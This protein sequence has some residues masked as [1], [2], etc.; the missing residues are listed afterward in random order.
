M[1]LEPHRLLREHAGEVALQ[2][3]V[4]SLP[5]AELGA[6]LRGRRSVRQ[7]GREP[8]T[9]AQLGTLLGLAAGATDDP[10]LPVAGFGPPGRRTY[11]S[12]GALYP[13]EILVHELAGPECHLYQVFTHRLVRFAAL[14]DSS[15][16]DAMVQENRIEGTGIGFFLF[17]DFARPSLR[18]Y[19]QLAER[20]ALLEAG[21][22][23]QN[24]L[25]VGTALGL[26][27]V[28]LCGFDVQGL[29]RSL[30]LSYPEQAVVYVIVMGV[31]HGG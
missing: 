11:P 2:F 16:I 20:L 21:H 15:V 12:G 29:S 14:V 27:G 7:F 6:A 5:H 28:P 13:I 3:P 31:Q 22:V 30:G 9:R 19:G 18:K 24:L 8:I 10:P 23:A 25:L 26:A 17:V 1:I 4:P